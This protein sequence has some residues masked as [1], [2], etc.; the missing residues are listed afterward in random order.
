MAADMARPAALGPGAPLEAGISTSYLPPYQPR[1][2]PQ[3]RIWRRVRYEATTNRW[4][5]T[6]DAIGDTVRRTTHSWSP[7]KIKR[8]CHIT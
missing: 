7:P 4:F 6:L 2:N 8:L 5:E 1:L 3:E